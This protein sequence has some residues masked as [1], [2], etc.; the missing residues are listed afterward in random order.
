[1]DKP[2]HTYGYE[3]TGEGRKGKREVARDQGLPVLIAASRFIGGTAKKRVVNNLVPAL[4]G[5]RQKIALPV[6]VPPLA[7]TKN[8]PKTIVLGG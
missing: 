7:A 1:M 6:I 8:R 4:L 2:I 5:G 3:R